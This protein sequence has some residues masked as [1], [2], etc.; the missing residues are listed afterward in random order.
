MKTAIMTAS[1]SVK[2]RIAT[3]DLVT[4][5]KRGETCLA[6]PCSRCNR[7]VGRTATSPLGCYDQRRFG[8]SQRAMLAQIMEWNRPD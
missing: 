4:R 3:P 6:N 1:A 5:F 2:G 8:G 7:C